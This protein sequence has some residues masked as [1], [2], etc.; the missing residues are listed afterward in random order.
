MYVCSELLG[1]EL[2]EQALQQVTTI[3]S[4]GS[5]GRADFH[6]LNGPEIRKWIKQKCSATLLAA[7]ADAGGV[8]AATKATHS[9]LTRWLQ[10]LHDHLLHK[11]EWTAKELEDW[12]AAV[13]DIQQHWCA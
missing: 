12:R 2:V 7:A 13:D 6:Q 10:Q 9:I 1:T 4:A 5:G 8:D 11:R 3:H